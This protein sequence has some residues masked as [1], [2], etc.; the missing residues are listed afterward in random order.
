[1]DNLL[2]K[3][4]AAA[5]RLTAMQGCNQSSIIWSIMIF[6]HALR[7]YVSIAIGKQLKEC[8]TTQWLLAALSAKAMILS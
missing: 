8:V 3:L 4:T 5:R 2:I 6:V 7:K 1:M